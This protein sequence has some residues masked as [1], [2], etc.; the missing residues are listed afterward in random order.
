MFYADAGASSSS[1]CRVLKFVFPD[2]TALRYTVS[3]TT[4]RP[5]ASWVTAVDTV[6]TP[7]ERIAFDRQRSGADAH[8]QA[9]CGR[10]IWP[11]APS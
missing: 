7:D 11:W 1:R 5:C 4:P 10:T 3:T 6:L 9:Q 8:R 2:S